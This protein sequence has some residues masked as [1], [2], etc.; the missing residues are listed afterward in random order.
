MNAVRFFSE[1]LVSLPN[2]AIL[3]IWY[4]PITISSNIDAYV[5]L[6]SLAFNRNCYSTDVNCRR[7]WKIGFELPGSAAGWPQT[8]EDA[9][10]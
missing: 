5:K 9:T 4:G 2:R 1:I 3:D 8:K 10:C 7:P 6:A